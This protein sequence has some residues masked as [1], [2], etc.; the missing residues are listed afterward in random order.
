MDLWDFP[1]IGIS[2][3]YDNKAEKTLPVKFF[4]GSPAILAYA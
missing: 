3:F 4:T 1:D 2:V